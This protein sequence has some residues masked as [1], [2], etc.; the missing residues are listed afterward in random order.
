MAY[1]IR[2]VLH[3]VTAGKR[4]LI[5]NRISHTSHGYDFNVANDERAT[6]VFAGTASNKIK[7]TVHNVDFFRSYF[8]KRYNGRTG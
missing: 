8:T 2:D 5:I 1:H 7:I 6:V 4:W 3:I